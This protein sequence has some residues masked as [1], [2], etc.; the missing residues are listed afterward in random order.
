[1]TL[2]DSDGLFS[3]RALSPVMAPQRSPSAKQRATGAADG[4]GA[5]RGSTAVSVPPLA[6]DVMLPRW[7]TNVPGSWLTD[8]F[9]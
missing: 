2:F 7:L 8:R 3:G 6:H 4:R 9:N 5:A 1:M